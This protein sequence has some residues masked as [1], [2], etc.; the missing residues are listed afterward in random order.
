MSGGRARDIEGAFHGG[1][2]FDRK[3]PAE[4]DVKDKL[5]VQI[6]RIE[7]RQVGEA[8]Q[9]FSVTFFYGLNERDNF[10]DYLFIQNATWSP[11]DQR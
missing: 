5:E 1:L 4:R 8:I 3:T 11:K 9:R 6:D 7:R 10:V 2:I